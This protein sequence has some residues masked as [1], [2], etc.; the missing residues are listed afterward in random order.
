[1]DLF[2]SL[3]TKPVYHVAFLSKILKILRCVCFH[4]GK[5]LVDANDSK[6]VDI[7]KKTKGQYRRRLAFVFDVCKG[8]KICKGLLKY[9]HCQMKFFVYLFFVR[10]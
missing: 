1:M 10:K 6:I 2:F 7:L 9:F 3:V 5:L 8:Q 4:C